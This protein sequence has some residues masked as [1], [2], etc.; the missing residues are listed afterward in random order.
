[1]AYKYA[2]K[3][4]T[5]EEITNLESIVVDLET[6]IAHATKALE[7]PDRLRQLSIKAGVGPDELQARWEKV[8]AQSQAE[9]GLAQ[10][11]LE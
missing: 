6:R 1:M 9:L 4:Y 11:L 2:D 10:A 3:I 7:N 5:Q 8:L